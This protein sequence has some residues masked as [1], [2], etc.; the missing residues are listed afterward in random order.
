MLALTTTAI[1]ET[2]ECVKECLAMKDVALIG[3]HPG[4]HNIK[5]IVK[6]SIKVDEVSLLL[7]TE[8]SELCTNAP[9]TV[10]FC[11]TLLQYANLL[12]SL[13]RQLKMNIT[14]PS[15]VPVTDIQYRLVDIFTSGSTS[16]MREVILQ[17]FCKRDT[18]LRFIIATTAFGLGV[19]CADIT[20]VIHWGSPNSL[21]ELAQETGRAGRD[22]SPSEAI[23][24]YKKLENLCQNL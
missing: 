21:E 15:S 6:P 20:R 3:L 5:Y 2:F 22:G 9:K 14:E 8:L 18:H 24:Y 10:I 11:R 19:D 13:K 17:E 12:K 16:D 23:L 1:Q 4:R 7:A